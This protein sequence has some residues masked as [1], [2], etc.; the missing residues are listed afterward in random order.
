[1]SKSGSVTFVAN[2]FSGTSTTLNGSAVIRIPK[3]RPPE[4]KK[5]EEEMEALTNT[6]KAKENQLVSFEE[7]F[8][9]VLYQGSQV[10]YKADTSLKYEF[11]KDLSKYFYYGMT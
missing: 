5:Y 11:I 9:L 1:M 7:K 6:I 8:R 2:T 3:V 10:H 4:K